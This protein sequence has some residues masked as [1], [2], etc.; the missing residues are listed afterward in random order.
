MIA[1]IVFVPLNTSFYCDPSRRDVGIQTPSS[2]GFGE[3][4]VQVAFQSPVLC[5]P[6][7][8]N[9]IAMLFNFRN[10]LDMYLFCVWYQ[11]YSVFLHFFC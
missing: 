6:F 10:G 4:A 7:L 3:R 5:P 8:M 1:R 11:N 2:V 9:G